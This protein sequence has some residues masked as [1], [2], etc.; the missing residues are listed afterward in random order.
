MYHVLALVINFILPLYLGARTTFLQSLEAQRILKAFAEEGITIFICVPQFFYL[1]HRRIMQE[2]GRQGALKRFLFRRLL[3][4]SRFANLHLGFN[5]GRYFFRAI[6]AKFGPSFRLFGVGGAR[7]ESEVAESFRDMGFGLAQAFGMT[8]TA[9]LITVAVQKGR[10]VG[11][12]GVAMPHDEVRIEAPDEN[13]IGEVL[14]RGENVMQ[15]YYKNP[16]ATAEAIQD[17]WLYTGD[18]GY[19]DRRGYLH[20]TGRKKDVIVLS[21][22]KNIYPEEI[23]KFYQSNSSYIKEICVVGIPEG[24]GEKLHAVVVPDFDGLKSDLAASAYD[25]I[26]W[27]L[28]TLSERLPSYKRV[29]SLE[30][31]REPLPAHHHPQGQALSR[32]SGKCWSE[33]GSRRRLWK[34]PRRRRRWKS[35]CSR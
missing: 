11:T 12:A 19:I 32:C 34:P 14:V 24:E 17:G 4:V 26:R 3:A 35:G 18:L 23:E 16:E 13:G 27:E 8:E 30:I 2:V 25:S 10:A 22:G 20:I 6:H 15:G 21:S 1:V 33:P 5:P 7:F 28:E 31:R 9:A 29:F